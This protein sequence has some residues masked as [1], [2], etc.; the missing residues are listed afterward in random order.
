MS[1]GTEPLASGRVALAGKLVALGLFAAILLLPNSGDAG[2]LPPA[3][4]RLA[5]VT[6]LMAVLWLTQALP[7]AATSLIPLAAF[8]LLGIQTAEAVSAAYANA[9]V[10]LFLGGFIIALGIEKWGLHRRMALHIVRL[11]GAGPR[12]IVLGFMLATGFLSMWISNTAATL[13]MLPIALALVTAL[14]E[15]PAAQPGPPADAGEE[16]AAQRAGFDRLGLALL[17]GIAYSSS[18]GGFTTLVGTPTNV[19]FQR[20][21]RL[22]FPEAPEFSVG[23]WLAAVLPIGAIMLVAAWLTLVRGLP[24]LPGTERLDRRFF[25]ERLRAL[26]RPSRAEWLML[27][28]FVATALLWIFRD[29]LLIGEMQV[30]PG[31]GELV[32]RR[33]V[34]AGVSPDVARRTLHDSVVAIGMALLMFVI[35]ARRDEYGRTEYLI[36]WQT[37]VRLPWGI[38]LLF[39]GGF[40]LADAFGATGLS[41][42][43]GRHFASAVGSWPPWLLVAAVCFL[44]TFLTELTS[45]VATIS[46]FLPLLAATAVSVG[47]DPR[48]ILVPATISTSCAF[49]LPIATPPNAIVFASGRVRMGQMARY[50]F[51]LN[52][53]GVVVVTLATFALLV[54]Q[55]GISLGAVPEWARRP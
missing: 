44:L 49:M 1:T 19:A 25:T 18:I 45:N 9:S 55:L 33:L 22:E 23:V 30:L 21:W 38:L 43:I 29:P 20:I 47:V 4:Q 2:A 53:I 42:W 6:A 31:W 24:D 27:A 39:G 28:V 32:E 10:F 14:G 5:A 15:L 12:R 17:L 7:I 36:D 13:L 3:A 50:G 37:A 54:P 16:P 8:P 51:A 11:V 41:E 26:G 34:G 52:L 48:L 40:A 35:P 46:T